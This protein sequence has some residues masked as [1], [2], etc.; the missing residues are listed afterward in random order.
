MEEKKTKR[1]STLIFIIFIIGA[2][3]VGFGVSTLMFNNNKNDNKTEEKEKETKKPAFDLETM[4]YAMHADA[5]KTINNIGLEASIYNKTEIYAKDFSTDELYLIFQK[6]LAS[7]KTDYIVNDVDTKEE[8]DQVIQY[9]PV[10]NKLKDFSKKLFGENFEFKDEYL[11]K[12]ME[13]SIG[14]APCGAVYHTKEINGK[15]YY[16]YASRA[17]GCFGEA[18]YNYKYDRT[19]TKDS[20]V[21]VYEIVEIYD[22]NTEKVNTTYTY[23]WTYKIGSDNMYHLYKINRE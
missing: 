8:Y 17:G 13:T 10:Y 6:Y 11:F 3:C 19:E 16:V 21:Y 18:V 23:K 22:V 15:K 9:E 2:F 12:N 4:Y 5:D 7:I 1:F 20:E 14:L